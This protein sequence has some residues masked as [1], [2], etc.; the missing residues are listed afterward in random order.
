M[1]AGKKTTKY[2]GEVFLNGTKRDHLYSR[3]TSYVPHNEIVPAY[4]T[5]SEAV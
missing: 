1:L 5:V 4:W 3:V 2:S